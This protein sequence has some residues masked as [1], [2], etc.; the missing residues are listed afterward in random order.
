MEKVTRSIIM[1]SIACGLFC[2]A[3]AY[4]GKYVNAKAV[5]VQWRH[6]IGTNWVAL[7][8]ECWNSFAI[9][10]LVVYTISNG[11][12][13]PHPDTIYTREKGFAH[14]PAFNFSGTKIAFFRSS[15][16]STSATATSGTTVNGGKS[17][18][19]IINVDGSGL[20]NLVE[21]PAKPEGYGQPGS[22]MLPLDWPA[23][24]WIYYEKPYAVTSGDP[25]G[26]N[27][28]RINAVTKASEVVCDLSKGGQCTYWRRFSMTADRSKMAGQTMGK[29]Q[30]TEIIS[31]GNCVWPIPIPG[32]DLA[33][34]KT[35]CRAACNI[36]ISP[37]GS[38]VGSYFAGAH[39]EM[40]LNDNTPN[41]YDFGW[42]KGVP[43]SKV[44]EWAGENVG[45]GCELIRWSANSDKWVMQNVG[46]YGH[47][48]AI[49]TGS[50]SVACDWVDQVAFNITKNPKP[51]STAQ[52]TLFINNCTGDMWISDPANNPN[53]ANYEDL[54]GV[55]HA[56]PGATAISDYRSGGRRSSPASGVSGFGHD[57]TTAIDMHGRIISSRSVLHGIYFRVSFADKGIYSHRE[58]NADVSR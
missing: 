44:A 5:S 17:Y 42:G 19:S 25:T 21:I 28:W 50:N 55:W 52:G 36:S 53:C 13:K 56:V 33:N 2:S 24:D 40:Q 57:A 1:V 8:S 11:V 37:S 10:Q 31:G 58:V 48:G 49:A 7:C 4:N 34:G 18:V 38:V 12:V 26:V 43:L 27:I 23:G 45:S 30:C 16:A 6:G 41:V 15:S 22:E 14:Y 20:E 51:P 46:W 39:T 54:S 9:G 47:A 32:C 29:Y 35:S 3:Y